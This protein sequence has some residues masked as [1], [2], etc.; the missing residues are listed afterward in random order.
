MGTKESMMK[1]F[2]L[3]FVLIVNLCAVD[4][5]Q[6]MMDSIAKYAIRIGTGPDHSYVFV[7]PLCPKSQ[8]FIELI[9]KRKDLQEKSSYYIFLYRLHKFDSAELI[10]YI[11]QSENPLEALKEIMIDKDYDGLED[12]SVQEKTLDI[13]HHVSAVARELH[14]KRRPYLLIYE[15][16]SHFC[17]VSEGTAPCLEENDFDN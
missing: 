15:E 8:H 10:E 2:M 16:G 1:V 13:I 5:R 7:D 11:Y 12:F 6:A 14:M 17:T 4:D 9:D 3:L